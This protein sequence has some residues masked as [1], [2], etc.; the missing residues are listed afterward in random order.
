MNNIKVTIEGVGQFSIDP[1]DVDSL[2][3]WLSNKNSI[4]LQREPVREVRE[5]K[6]TG[7]ILITE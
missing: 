2:V 4:R 3:A 1:N 7:K 5:D 6:F